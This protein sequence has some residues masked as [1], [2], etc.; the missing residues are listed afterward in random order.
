MKKLIV[1][2]NNV[3]KIKE[4]K[5]ILSKY[6]I[7]IVSLKEAGINV[8]VEENGET[9]IENAYIKANEIYK[10]VDNAMVLADD[11][12]LMVDCLGGAPG[13]YSARF[14]GE[15]GNDKKNNEKLIGLLQGKKTEERK[16][17]FVCAIVLIIDSNN[18]IKVQGE[19]EGIIL[20]EEKGENGFGYDPLFYVPEHKV[21][22]AEMD[23][24]LKNSISHRAKALKKLEGR[25]KEL[26]MEG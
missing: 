16:G 6:P 26:M 3:K 21:T 14:A 10:M 17:K 18:V 15:H 8:D 23:A 20:E 5:E 12:G 2:S 25:M 13:V 9:F 11:S 22:F 7:E 19:V 4:I 1:A 24:V